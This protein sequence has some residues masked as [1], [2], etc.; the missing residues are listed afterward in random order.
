MGF[1]MEIRFIDHLQI[2]TSSIYNTTTNLQILQIITA[3]AK[4]SQSSFISCFLVLDF[5][6]RD[7][8]ASVFKLLLSGAHPTTALLLKL[9]NSQAGSHLTTTS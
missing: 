8:S 4:P 2:I 3:H 6:N 5:N 9:A 1:E 7:S